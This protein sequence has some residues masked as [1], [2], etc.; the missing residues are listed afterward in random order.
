MLQ[1]RQQQQCH[2]RCGSVFAS[3]SQHKPTPAMCP[4][5]CEQHP[6]STPYRKP[7]I[8]APS[9]PAL[10]PLPKPLVC[11]KLAYKTR[12]V[13]CLLQQSPLHCPCHVPGLTAAVPLQV[14]AGVRS[15]G[16]TSNTP[17]MCPASDAVVNSLNVLSVVRQS[18]V[19]L[20]PS[21]SHPRQQQCH[22]RCGPVSAQRQRDTKAPHLQCALPAFIVTAT[23]CL[24]PW[25]PN[26][27]QPPHQL[28]RKLTPPVPQVEA[29]HHPNVNVSAANIQVAPEVH[30]TRG[31]LQCAFITEAHGHI[32]RATHTPCACHGDHLCSLLCSA[33]SI[34][35]ASQYQGHDSI[36]VPGCRERT[37][38]L[39]Y[40][41]IEPLGFKILSRW[42][43]AGMRESQLAVIYIPSEHPDP[44]PDPVQHQARQ[45]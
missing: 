6:A 7:Q 44:S 26:A 16:G 32:L 8:L 22:G 41:K 29:N 39:A 25:Q 24:C 14:W 20:P 40:S 1:A 19:A 38:M 28:H 12:A 36:S 30:Y 15:S 3:I 45:S 34:T 21:V 17:A 31:A 37:C 11:N 2:C 35:I 23:P 42:Q 43:P 9:M 33:A 10:P 27:R 4:P 13:S 18:C 5:C